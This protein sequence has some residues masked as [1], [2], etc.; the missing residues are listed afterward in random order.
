MVVKR[1][2]LRRISVRSDRGGFRFQQ[3]RICFFSLEPSI[4]SGGVLG[5]RLFGDPSADAIGIGLRGHRGCSSYSTD[6]IL[7]LERMLKWRR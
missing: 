2:L 6:I 1:G 3:L 4:Y 5:R 7:E